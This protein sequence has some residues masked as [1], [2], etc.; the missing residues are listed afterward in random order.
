M[1]CRFILLRNIK[2]LLIFSITF[3]LLVLWAFR[4]LRP[5]D[6]G[7]KRQSKIYKR[8]IEYHCAKAIS[9]ESTAFVSNIQFRLFI[10]AHDERSRRIAENWMKCMPFARV[11][12]IPTT[13][14][15]ESIV[16]RNI[17]HD[18]REEW[19]NLDL[20]GLATYNSLQFSSIEKLKAY[21]ELAYYKPYD[22]I[23]LYDAGEQLV[24]ITLKVFLKKFNYVSNFFFVSV[25]SGC[26]RSHDR[27]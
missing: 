12:M 26:F 11:I 7:T 14:F 24:R 23:P 27:V 9:K 3:F 5:S 17:L 19:E 22:V 25:G 21:V 2:N 8:S 1:I 10:L 20:V 6:K 13:F 4:L 16:Y 18:I 15:F